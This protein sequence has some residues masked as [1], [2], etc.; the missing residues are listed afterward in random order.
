MTLSWKSRLI[1]SLLRL[2]SNSLPVSEIFGPILPIVPVDSI[3]D[4]I[5][6]V[7]ARSETHIEANVELHLT[8]PQTAPIGFVRVHG[9]PGCEIAE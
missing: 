9:K 5:D 8:G 3:L 6:F 1:Y 4:A 2:L 7:N